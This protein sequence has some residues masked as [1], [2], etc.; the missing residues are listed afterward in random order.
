MA[1]PRSEE[2]RR[3]VLDATVE[4]VVERGVG[5]LTIDEL[6]TRSGVAK[7]T[8]YRHWA[9]RSALLIDAARNTFEHV[10]TPDTGTLRGDLGAFFE[11]MVRAD[12]TGP[13]GRLMPCLIEASHRDAEIEALLDQ[14]AEERQ[15]PVL[16]IVERARARGE[17]TSDVDPAVLV[18]V[19]VGPL[20]FRKVMMRRPVGRA[21]M[22]ACLDIVVAGLVSE[23]S[24]GTP[25][26]PR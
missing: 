14:L 21:Y 24:R 18:G 23:P 17:L 20:L 8:I 16:A 10:N 26:A 13:T 9:D 15:R 2:A 7:T 3:K 4:I 12:M 1:R 22:D 19:I 11:H 6:V 5:S 25:K